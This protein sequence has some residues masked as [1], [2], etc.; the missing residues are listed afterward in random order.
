LLASTKSA[1][2]LSRNLL[3][4][5]ELVAIHAL[6]V[7]GEHHGDAIPKR[8]VLPSDVESLAALVVPSRADAGPDFLATLVFAGGLAVV[9]DVGWSVWHGVGLLILSSV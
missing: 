1:E 2:D 5:D 8:E 6:L 9:E 3:V 7:V 4:R